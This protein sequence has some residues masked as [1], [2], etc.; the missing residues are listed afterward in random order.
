MEKNT[1][2]SAGQ[3]SEMNTSRHKPLYRYYMPVEEYELCETM[4]EYEKKRYE[5]VCE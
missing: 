1:T 4:V 5:V 2:T 3:N